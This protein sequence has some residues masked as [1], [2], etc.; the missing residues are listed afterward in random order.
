MSK[1]GKILLWVALAGAV[2]AIGAGV[3]L[4]FQY[5]DTKSNLAQTTAAKTADDQTIVKVKAENTQLA[6]AKADSDKQLADATSKISDLNTQL[7]TAQ[8]QAKDAATAVKTATD[9]A[10]TA[11]DALDAI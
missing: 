5:N 8:Q 11:K 7:T 2:V 9:A 1:L 3:A 6:A 10:K 4:I